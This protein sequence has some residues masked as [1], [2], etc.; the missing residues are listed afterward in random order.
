M[1]TIYG[2]WLILTYLMGSKGYP[3]RIVTVVN[4]IWVVSILLLTIK[5]SIYLTKYRSIFLI[6]LLGSFF[7]INN[8]YSS[9]INDLRTN[10]LQIFKEKMDEQYF[11]LTSAQKEEEC[12]SIVE[13][14]N[15]DSYL[16]YSIASHPYPTPNREDV[17]MNGAYEKYFQINEINLKGDTVK[18][19]NTINEIINQ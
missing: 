6:L 13:L 11:I 7:I 2:V 18:V 16:P 17:H 19:L 1:I 9:I 10:K 5:Y 8:S 15:I 4:P 3:A 12:F 14:E